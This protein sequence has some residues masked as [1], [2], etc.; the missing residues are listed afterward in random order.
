MNP[1]GDNLVSSAI[2]E[3]CDFIHKENITSL[4]AHIVTKHLSAD[5]ESPMPSL[6]DISSPYV[7]TLTTLRL[8]YEEKMAF[9]KK[10]S[11]NSTEQRV[12]NDADA[13]SGYIYGDTASRSVP[14]TMNEKAREDQRKFREI[15][16]EESYF[17][18]DDDETPATNPG[19]PT[20]GV[21][22]VATQDADQLRA[23][24]IFSLIQAPHFEGTQ[25]RFD[26]ENAVNHTEGVASGGHSQ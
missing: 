19:V 23:P 18:A 22:E 5:S 21:D 4:L 16:K 24:R 3:M 15:D 14:S 1:V 12:A 9:S 17:D 6:E 7:T 20:G 25:R 11:A 13:H 2:V 8:A 10:S 26:D